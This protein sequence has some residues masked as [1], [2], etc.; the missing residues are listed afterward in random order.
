MRL[1]PTS[2]HKQEIGAHYPIMAVR[3]AAMAI[4]WLLPTSANNNN[5]RC[6]GGPSTFG[7][8]FLGSLVTPAWPLLRNPLRAPKMWA[9]GLPCLFFGDCSLPQA[10]GTRARPAIR[11]DG[12]LQAITFLLPKQPT[13]VAAAARGFGG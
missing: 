2:V 10:I 8:L 12:R 5:N 13:A 7:L 1:T 3:G 4:F 6:E 11:L 9:R